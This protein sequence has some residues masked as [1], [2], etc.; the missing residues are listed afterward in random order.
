[1]LAE[2][3]V[4]RK[5]GIKKKSKI[6]FHKRLNIILFV[7]FYC[8]I[9]PDHRMLN[10]VLVN[11]EIPQNTGNVARSV[12]ANKC[13]LHLVKPIGFSIDDKNL[14]RAGLDYW[15]FI[16]LKVWENIE[17][18]FDQTDIEKIHLFST[19]GDLRY[20]RAEY[21]HGDYLVFGSE[22]S[23]LSPQLL[24]KNK[25]RTRF[26]PISDQKVRSLNLSSA[27]SVAIYEALRQLD[28]SCQG[29]Q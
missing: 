4:L 2:A 24:N 19:R 12:I 7:V 5:T 10:I 15:Q 25:E 21:R 29:G 1:M 23:G 3:L 8:G 17:Q 6:V 11:P 16:D 20:D 13:S 22:S 18:F 28:F 9:M 27:V 14:K 26:L